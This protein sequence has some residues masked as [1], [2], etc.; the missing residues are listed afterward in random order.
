MSTSPISHC[1][2]HDA[3]QSTNPQFPQQH[4]GYA[5]GIN[6]YKWNPLSVT[7]AISPFSGEATS[8]VLFQP[9][10]RLYF[11]WSHRLP[12]V[13][14]STAPLWINLSI[15]YKLAN[16]CAGC[17]FE[18][19]LR[20]STTSLSASPCNSLASD[21][22]PN[23]QCLLISQTNNH[24]SPCSFLSHTWNVP[25]L[26]SY[27]CCFSASDSSSSTIVA[28]NVTTQA[29][30][31]SRIRPAGTICTKRQLNWGFLIPS[32]YF[33]Q[34]ILFNLTLMVL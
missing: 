18:T 19:G 20:S 23:N 31:K 25:I 21:S 17:Q 12:F 5:S 8:S 13:F 29:F 26:L 9:L 2:R 30:S 28:T 27:I 22:R 4:T 10:D 16:S 32:D 3:I 33:F 7:D 6:L 15:H 11:L 14:A 1:R 24:Q 34:A